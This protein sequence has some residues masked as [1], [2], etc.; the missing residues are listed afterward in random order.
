M[1]YNSAL[2]SHVLAVALPVLGALQAPP[3]VS[4]GSVVV[5]GI[6]LWIVLH[7]SSTWPLGPG[8]RGRPGGRGGEVV[9]EVRISARD[10]CVVNRNDTF[11][12]WRGSL[13]GG[14]SCFQGAF[15]KSSLLLFCSSLCPSLWCIRGPSVSLLFYSRFAQTCGIAESAG[16]VRIALS[17]TNFLLRTAEMQ[18]TVLLPRSNLFEGL[19]VRH[20]T[21]AVTFAS[22]DVPVIAMVDY[23]LMC[24]G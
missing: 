21:F 14:V 4:T 2:L 9:N 3:R 16:E 8:G 19:E 6:S 7:Y 18:L 5:L 17:A 15:S 23:Y 22:S 12:N 20:L 24:S 11:H 1:A 13:V 10:V